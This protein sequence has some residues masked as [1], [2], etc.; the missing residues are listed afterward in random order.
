MNVWTE[1]AKA[2]ITSLGVDVVELEVVGTHHHF[3]SFRPR[4]KKADMEKIKEETK[5]IQEG[6]T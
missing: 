6:K 1:E 3:Q 2:A 5:Q 4:A